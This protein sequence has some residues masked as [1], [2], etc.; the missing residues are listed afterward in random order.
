MRWAALVPLLGWVAL[1]ILP[2]M[3]GLSDPNEGVLVAREAVLRTAD[4]AGAPPR[5]VDPLPAGTEVTVL[6]PRGDWARVQLADGRD[7]WVRASQVRTL[8]D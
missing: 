2:L 3:D 8:A 6:E 7:G 4:A 1:T 5:L